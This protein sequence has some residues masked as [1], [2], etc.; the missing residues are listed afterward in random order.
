MTKRQKHVAMGFLTLWLLVVLVIAR[1]T[2]SRQFRS[3]QEGIYTEAQADRGAKTTADVCQK[4]HPSDYYKGRVVEAWEGNPVAA[5]YDS[6]VETMPQDRPSSLKP[7]Q[8]VDIVAYMFELNDYPKGENELSADIEI[9]Q[10]IIIEGSK[11]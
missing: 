5:L 7:Q 1:E 11:E 6:I 10:W 3:T 4:C 9:L 2:Q 8:Y